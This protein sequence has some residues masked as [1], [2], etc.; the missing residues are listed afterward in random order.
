MADYADWRP[1]VADVAAIVAQRT[2]DPDGDARSSFR[3]DTTPSATQV[4][5]L[6]AQVQSRVAT[7]V[8]VM[9]DDLA[10]E[11]VPGDGPGSTPAGH[12]VALGA[13]ALV[14]LQFWPDMA[15]GGESPA[16]QLREWYM[17]ALDELAASAE[18]IRSDG[19]LG[20]QP[21]RPAW[22]FPDTVGTGR[23]TTPWERY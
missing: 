9:P 22:A 20:T 21:V 12:V 18:D 19:E 10:A 16:T 3:S 6:I 1:T 14:E 13:A 17:A 15:Q 11:L 8:G 5:T 23:A 2:G 4:E 7:R